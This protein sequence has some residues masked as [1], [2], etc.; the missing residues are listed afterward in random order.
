V[1]YFAHWL[2]LTEYSG[3]CQYF[4]YKRNK[5]GKTK[6]LTMKHYENKLLAKVERNIMRKS[7]SE[8]DSKGVN[9]YFRPIES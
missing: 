6:S 7:A 1:A 8:A 9:P 4:F 2:C 3:S 5:R